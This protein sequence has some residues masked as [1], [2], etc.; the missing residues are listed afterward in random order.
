MSK[1]GQ[2]EYSEYLIFLSSKKGAFPN[3]SKFETPNRRG[4]GALQ[5]G[6]LTIQWAELIKVDMKPYDSSTLRVGYPPKTL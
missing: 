4:G 3:V 2:E 6:K 1:F 5:I